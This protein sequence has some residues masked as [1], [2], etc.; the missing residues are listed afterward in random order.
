[1]GVYFACVVLCVCFARVVRVVCVVLCMCGAVCVMRCVFCVYC[2]LCV[3]CVC[4]VVFGSVIQILQ[5]T[6]PT[7]NTRPQHHTHTHITHTQYTTHDTPQHTTHNTHTTTHAPRKT[8]T[9]TRK[10]HLK[11]SENSHKTQKIRKNIIFNTTQ[12]TQTWYPQKTV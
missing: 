7:H 11:H 8:Y 12:H 2:V 6:S 5:H 9:I 4:C 3:L 10:T 1:M